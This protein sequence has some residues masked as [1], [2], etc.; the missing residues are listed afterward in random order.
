[1][2]IDYASLDADAVG[3]ITAALSRR[4]AEN[5]LDFPVRLLLLE[6]TT[7][8]PWLGTVKCTASGTNKA[9]VR[10]TFV[11]LDGRAEE[12]AGDLALQPIAPETLWQFMQ[13][14]IEKRRGTAPGQ[15]ETLQ[16]L[17]DID[18]QMRPLYAAFLA[19][20]I[21]RNKDARKW[22]RRQLLDDVLSYERKKY[23]QPYNVTEQHENLL[24]LAT[25]RGGLSHDEIKKACKNDEDGY[26]PEWNAT[27]INNIIKAIHGSSDTG[28]LSAFEPDIL[29]EVFVLERLNANRQFTAK[30]AEW[31]WNSSPFPYAGFVD[32][33]AQDFPASFVP[34]L[35]GTIF[36]INDGQQAHLAVMLS[37]NLIN[38]LGKT[39]EHRQTAIELYG[40][41]KALAK[42]Q[43]TSEIWLAQAQAA[44]NLINALGKTDEHRQTAIELYGELK[45][46]A[47]AQDASEIWLAPAQAAFNLISALVKTD[48]HRQTAIELYG[49]FKVLAKAQDISEI[50]LRQAQAAAKLITAIGDTAEHHQTAIE[51]YG[52]LKALA[53]AQDIAG[54]WLAQAQAAFNLIIFL[55][56]TDEHRQMAVELYGEFKALA[57]VQDTAEIWLR[58]AQA[59]VN[60]ISDLG[61]A[62]EHSQM[63]IELYGELKALAKAQDTAEIWQK[64]SEGGGVMIL[65]ALLRFVPAEADYF[66][67]SLEAFLKSDQ[68]K[69]A[70]RFVLTAALYLRA[71]ELENGESFEQAKTMIMEL[72]DIYDAVLP[73][74]EQFRTMGLGVKPQD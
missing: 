57:K 41:L 62:D 67:M 64:M 3:N 71:C 55:G 48:E 59:A 73:H 68:E 24:A 18:P 26:L 6:R 72:G 65:G 56:K 34:G 31:A 29:G 66:A 47:K 58:Q 16:M 2:V 49:E 46:L 54:I 32:R 30:L 9:A 38:V 28:F 13:A 74:L 45:A 7:D 43:N 27:D 19:D 70:E 5:S 17:S 36:S 39:D 61:E 63:A 21:G 11:R 42:K 40:E 33:L 4:N 14:I 15:A 25:V 53:K 69:A 51:L 50:W 20:A 8:G 35:V 10:D 23:W 52:E 37:I 44:V 1:M 22:D 60:L 12:G